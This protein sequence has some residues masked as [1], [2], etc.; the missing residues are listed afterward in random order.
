MSESESEV[1]ALLTFPIPVD[2]L[3]AAVRALEALYGP[4]LVVDYGHPLSG[5]YMVISRPP[6]Q[7]EG[8][9]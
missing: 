1:V 9:S 5:T 3:G 4:N 6:A 2:A 7:S 8:T